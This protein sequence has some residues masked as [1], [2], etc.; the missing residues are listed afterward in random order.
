MVWY[1]G[2]LSN[3]VS[4]K[5]CLRPT[6]LFTLI[7]LTHACLQVRSASVPTQAHGRYPA[8]APTPQAWWFIANQHRRTTAWRM[9]RW[10]V[11]C[12]SKGRTSVAGNCLVSECEDFL[13]GSC[14]S[15]EP[16]LACCSRKWLVG[17]ARCSKVHAHGQQN[18]LHGAA[19]DFISF[20]HPGLP[21]LAAVIRT[22]WLP[23]SAVRHGHVL[24]HHDQRLPCCRICWTTG[25]CR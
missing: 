11:G 2:M 7:H 23:A 25:P 5:T 14:R 18:A 15:V 24:R 6:T 20:I 1:T 9:P 4:L 17:P 12:H 21:V 22:R 16:M 10:E 3:L 8:S 13:Q 19:P